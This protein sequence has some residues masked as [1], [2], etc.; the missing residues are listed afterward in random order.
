[1]PKKKEVTSMSASSWSAVCRCGLAALLLSGCA[2]KASEAPAP[3][4]P[5]RATVVLV[6]LD[7]FRWDYLDRGLTPYLSRLAREGVRAEAMVPV[8][9]TKT[10]PNHYTIVTGRYPASHGIVGNVFTAPD[11]GARL[12][13]WDSLAVRDARFYL[14]EPIWTT[15]ERQGLRTAPLFWPGS[16]AQ[17]NGV[18]PSYS[19]P[20]DGRLPDTARVRQLLHWLDLPAARRPAFLTLYSATVDNAGHD[21]GPDAPETDQAIARVD[22]LMGFL[23][24]ELD[25]RRR[26]GE[27]NLVIVSDHGMISTGPGRV[28]WLDEYLAEDAIEVDEMSAL[29]TAWPAA[30]LDDSVYRALKRAPHLEVYRRAE[31]PARFRL[32]ESPRLAPI[33]AIADP[34]WTIAMRTAEDSSPRIILGNHGYDDSVS[35]MRAI[36][37]GHGP[38]FRHGVVVPPFRNIHVYPL[39]THLLGIDPAPGDGSLD[40]VRAMLATRSKAVRR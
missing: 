4:A 34:G 40:S 29:L 25:R 31:L 33:M 11:V 20:F 3:A 7:G 13:L 9:P 27:L 30:G 28:V 17:I 15:A 2:G 14:V 23:A 26:I 5:G 37:I 39:L 36:F 1:M 19:L 21:F 24:G 8:F 32:R 38:G 12:T 10:F 35:A 6:S 18:R 22:S 16:Q